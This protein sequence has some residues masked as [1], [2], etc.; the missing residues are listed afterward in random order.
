LAIATNDENASMP[1]VTGVV[2]GVLAGVGATGDWETTGLSH[3]E[4][5]VIATRVTKTSADLRIGVC[6]PRLYTNVVRDGEDANKRRH[7]PRP[8]YGVS[9]M[10]FE[11]DQCAFDARNSPQRGKIIRPARANDFPA[12]KHRQRSGC[13]WY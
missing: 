7:S 9:Q 5:A 2:V 11:K 13:R 3:P 4:K 1:G 6:S 10:R 8:R 12:R